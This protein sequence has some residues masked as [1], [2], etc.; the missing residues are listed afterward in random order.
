M[1][2]SQGFNRLA[3]VDIG[4]DI[5]FDRILILKTSKNINRRLTFGG[6]TADKPTGRKSMYA[7]TQPTS[8]SETTSTSASSATSQATPPR[9]TGGILVR[10]AYTPPLAGPS[11]NFNNQSPVVFTVKQMIQLKPN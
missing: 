3:Y 6:M 5:D 10:R 4:R 2:N 7:L 1:I 9:T 8:T 11:V